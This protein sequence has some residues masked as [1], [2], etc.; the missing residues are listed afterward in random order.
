MEQFISDFRKGEVK[1]LIPVRKQSQPEKKDEKPAKRVLSPN[2][3]RAQM[4]EERQPKAKKA[5]KG[6]KSQQDAARK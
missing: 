3:I 2:T 5:K 4:K 1:Q 6:K